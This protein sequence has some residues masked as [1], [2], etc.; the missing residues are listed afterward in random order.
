MDRTEEECIIIQNY[1]LLSTLL[2]FDPLHSRIIRISLHDSFIILVSL[3]KA[4]TNEI[5][6]ILSLG[7][8]PVAAR[9]PS[10]PSPTA[11]NQCVARKPVRKEISQLRREK[12]TAKIAGKGEN[13][14]KYFKSGL[15]T[16][17]VE[18]N[19]L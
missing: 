17:R 8:N 15:G 16:P 4:E 7:P 18:I 9:H 19:V 10:Y 5:I 1:G 14:R 2:P 6:N 3:L 12:N 13:T 11:T